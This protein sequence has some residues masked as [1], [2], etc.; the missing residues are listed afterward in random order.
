MRFYAV[1]LMV[2]ALVLPCMPQSGWKVVTGEWS[3][4]SQIKGKINRD[5]YRAVISY[6]PV[7]GEV[8]LLESESVG[9]GAIK[10]HWTTILD[11]KENTGGI[12]VLFAEHT[13]IQSIKENNVNGESLYGPFVLE[14]GTGKISRAI[15]FNGKVSWQDLPLLAPVPHGVWSMSSAEHTIAMEKMRRQNIYSIFLREETT[16]AIYRV[17]SCY[18]PDKGQI[19][20]KL[21]PISS[22][23]TVP[24]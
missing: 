5:N 2:S 4:L 7:S 16:G 8:R 15:D 11:P 12:E 24:R 14:K 18:L 17:E 1:F 9:A 6:N 3:V 13:L 20:D 19:W 10:E 23:E 22:K 21:V